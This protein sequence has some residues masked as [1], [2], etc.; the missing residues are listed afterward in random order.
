MIPS[1][2]L[3]LQFT[4]NSSKIPERIELKYVLGTAMQIIASQWKILEYFCLCF[5]S[6]PPSSYHNFLHFSHFIPLL[7]ELLLIHAYCIRTKFGQKAWKMSP[8]ICA[9]G[10]D[11][12]FL[13]LLL[14]RVKT[15][16]LPWKGV[17][18]RF[19]VLIY[20]SSN[21]IGCHWVWFVSW[22]LWNCCVNWAQILRDDFYWSADGFKL[23]SIPIQPPICRKTEKN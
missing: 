12:P 22:I 1:C 2:I 3:T 4:C 18:N 21:A 10:I 16:F 20:P 9:E 8:A 11:G 5:L 17:C 23:K 19:E 6:F 13:P 15:C 7:Q 14:L